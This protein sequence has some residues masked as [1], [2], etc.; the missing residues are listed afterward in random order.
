MSAANFVSG[1]W[2]ILKEIWSWCEF[3]TILDP[4]E[5]GIQ[6]R[7]GRF[8]RTVTGGWWVHR[9]FM[10]DEFF[11][12]NVRP[13]AMTLNEQALTTRD[14]KDI[15]VQGVLMW[16]IFDI[17]KSLLDVEDVLETLEQIAIGIVQDVVETQTWA[18]IR[19]PECRIEIKKAIQAQARK[20]GVSV[21]TFK[22]QS[23]VQADA[24][25]IFGQLTKPCNGGE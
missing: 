15:V 17:K 12:M 18:Y 22:F 19:T 24:Y 6:V 10:I 14:N 5:E 21:S 25:K 23:I 2:E 4:W 11:T 13:T 20:W 1:F 7:L 3:I 9:P 8:K 16:G